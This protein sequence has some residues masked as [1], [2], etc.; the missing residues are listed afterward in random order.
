MGKKI[1]TVSVVFLMMLIQMS[2]GS[3]VQNGSFESGDFAGWTSYDGNI[4]V[5]S[6]GGGV[7]VPSDGVYG[8][9]MNSGGSTPNAELSQIISTQIGE[10][11]LLAFDYAKAGSGSGT[12]SLQVKVDGFAILLDETIND[13]TGGLPGAYEN[14]SFEFTA[15]SSSLS[16]SFADLSSG[17]AS[18]D[19]VLDNVSIQAIP[20][21]SAAVLMGSA[22]GCIFFFRKRFRS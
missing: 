13:N 22:S 15:D 1:A 4:F 18:F 12:A 9:I 17:S 21:P 14:Y 8:A 11:Y 2:H 3:I 20:E 5:S 7:A 16:L 10:S 19:G 6:F